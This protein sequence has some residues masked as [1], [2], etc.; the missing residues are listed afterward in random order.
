M[1]V[2]V[3]K[4]H[5]WGAGGVDE[6]MYRAEMTRR[7]PCRDVTICIVVERCRWGP[8]TGALR[9]AKEDYKLQRWRLEDA[10]MGLRKIVPT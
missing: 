2:T 1:R 10:E 8:G 6:Y 5:M 4:S 3:Y 9:V 7:P